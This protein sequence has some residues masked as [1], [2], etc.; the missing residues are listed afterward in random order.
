MLCVQIFSVHPWGV[1]MRAGLVLLIVFMATQS[2][3]TTAHTLSFVD[4][5]P[6]LHA[7]KAFKKSSA[8]QTGD[9]TRTFSSF[10]NTLS[11]VRSGT[12]TLG[13]L[14][15]EMPNAPY[16]FL[17]D[18]RLQVFAA[19]DLPSTAIDSTVQYTNEAYEL[20]MGDAYYGKNQA[21]AIYVMITGQDLE[22]GQEANREY[23][24][25]ILWV[26]FPS[27]EWCSPDTYI[28]YVTNGGA[29]INSSGP[30]EGYYFMVMGARNGELDSGYKTMTYHEV[31][32]I[33]QMSNVFSDSYDEVDSKMGRMSGDN[34]SELVAWWMEGNAD[35]FS[36]L[37]T[38]DLEGFKSEMV[39]ALEGTGPF[40]I[41]RKQ[42]FFETGIKLYNLSWDQGDTV[43]LGYRLGSWFVAYLVNSHGED[44][45]YKFWETVDKASFEDTFLQQFGKDYRAYIDEFEVWLGQPNEALYLI[46]DGLYNAKVR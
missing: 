31:F 22:A 16:V 14:K 24:D 40:D 21:K 34:P 32:H 7:D 4:G 28:E 25:Y 44:K 41:P 46:L 15:P 23:C 3:S 45:V 30:V 36:T 42:K 35:F 17:D 39:W 5:E 8:I 11:I 1:S 10:L 26:G 20:W 37:Y 13:V 38:K 6:V 2:A 29:G 12:S 33:Y 43:D 18:E 9:T 19:S 27:A